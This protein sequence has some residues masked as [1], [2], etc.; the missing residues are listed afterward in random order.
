MAIKKIQPPAEDA[1]DA[2]KEAYFKQQAIAAVQSQMTWLGLLIGLILAVAG[3]VG[4][5]N[6]L[7]RAE[8]NAEEKINITVNQRVQEAIAKKIPDEEIG[9]RI[10]DTAAASLYP[11]SKAKLD[12]MLLD[13]DSR[14]VKVDTPYFLKNTKSG[15]YLDV[16][17]AG[18]GGVPGQTDPV[19]IDGVPKTDQQWIV[20]GAATK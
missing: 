9:K 6:I 19:R 10:V 13:A 14:Y 11:E 4:Y 7:T 1:S 20:A 3:F 18:Q 15:L 2:G 16:F 8:Q 5:K 12:A 17:Y